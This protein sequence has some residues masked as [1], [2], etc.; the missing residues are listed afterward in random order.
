MV[1]EEYEDVVDV[2]I[3]K[4]VSE[5][6]GVWSGSDNSGSL[7]IKGQANL[8]NNVTVVEDLDQI[9][10]LF[11]MLDTKE[12][13]KSLLDASI[14][15]EGVQIFIGSEN[16]LFAQSGCSMVIAPYHSSNDRV[17]GAIGV[18]GPAA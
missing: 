11:M 15:A 16:P 2:R 10:N 5:G 1:F 8:L 7:I 12:S 18:V 9:R 3:H 14:K 13:L 6:I 17:L 4:I